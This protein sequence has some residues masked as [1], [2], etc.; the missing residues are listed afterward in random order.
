M[1]EDIGVPSH[2]T[3][4]RFEGENKLV[5]IN[6]VSLIL[7]YDDDLLKLD[8]TYGY[9]VEQQPIGRILFRQYCDTKP[10]YSKC[11]NFLDAVVTYLKINFL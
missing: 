6:F 7:D 11:N 5:K 3:L 1:E 8:V 2:I 9:I 10:Y 4:H